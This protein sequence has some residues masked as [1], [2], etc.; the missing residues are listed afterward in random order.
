[1]P[2]TASAFLSVHLLL[3]I[4]LLW[5]VARWGLAVALLWGV[6]LLW[7]VATCTSMTAV[8]RAVS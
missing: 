8:K 5:G 3:A 2:H 7:R 4:A 1:M 6:A